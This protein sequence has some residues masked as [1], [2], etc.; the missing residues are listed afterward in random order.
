M[1]RVIIERKVLQDKIP[2]Y[3]LAVRSVRLDAM[4]Q[5]GYISGETLRD[6]ADPCRFVTLSTWNS[7]EAWEE[8][9]A[10]EERRD[11]MTRLEAMLAGAEHITVLEP[12]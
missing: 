5:A 7:R 9:A 10:S 6:V 4:E 11:S 3:R 1:V 2:A 12:A 8:W